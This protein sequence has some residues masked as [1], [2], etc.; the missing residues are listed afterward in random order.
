M[1]RNAIFAM[2]MFGDIAGRE[3]LVAPI[4][5]RFESCK[6]TCLNNGGGGGIQTRGLRG[7]TDQFFARKIMS[8]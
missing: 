2:F 4:E 3:R 6:A 8:L 7:V 5:Q 1:G